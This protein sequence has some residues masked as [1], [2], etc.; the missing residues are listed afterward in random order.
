MNANILNG[1]FALRILALKIFLFIV[2]SILYIF[3]FSG[4]QHGQADLGT[5]HRV[6]GSAVGKQ[7]QGHFPHGHAG[8]HQQKQQERQTGQV[9]TCHQED[10]THAWSA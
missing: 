6:L 8:L 1:G 7:R 9:Y 2:D 10:F 3:P 4:F 5:L